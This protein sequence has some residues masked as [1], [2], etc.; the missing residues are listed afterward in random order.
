VLHP[1][2][3]Q[4]KV[5]ILAKDKFQGKFMTE[6]EDVYK[7]VKGD[8]EEIDVSPGVAMA[9]SVKDDEE[10]VLMLWVMN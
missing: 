5:G 6:W 8:F 7:L 10:Q 2:N 4:D 1:T 3:E 9:M